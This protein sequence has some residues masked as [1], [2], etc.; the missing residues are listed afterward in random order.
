MGFSR[1]IVEPSLYVS[2]SKVLRLVSHVDD[3]IAAGP[4]DALPKLW[5]E[6]HQHALLRRGDR[7]T[8]DKP[9]KFL[10]KLYYKFCE[11]GRRG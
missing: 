4:D 3:P 10:G 5:D 8:V 9:M 7:L 2:S 11:N 1:G 6:L